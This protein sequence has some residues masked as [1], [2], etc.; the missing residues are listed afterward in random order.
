MLEPAKWQS[1]TN[2]PGRLVFAF[3]VVEAAGA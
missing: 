2:V 3:L 1:S